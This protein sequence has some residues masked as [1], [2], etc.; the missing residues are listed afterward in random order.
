MPNNLSIIGQDVIQ[1]M[2]YLETCKNP[3]IL[4]SNG[5]HN[6]LDMV[7]HDGNLLSQKIY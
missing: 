3:L 4:I 5:M 6:T 2:N 7:V 1:L